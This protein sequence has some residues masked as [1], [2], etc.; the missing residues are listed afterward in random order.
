[1]IDC[2]ECDGTGFVTVQCFIHDGTGS[3]PFC[4]DTLEMETMCYTCNGTGKK[5]EVA[6][7]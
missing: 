6:N 3:C 4:D 5:G 7:E 1:M 2:P